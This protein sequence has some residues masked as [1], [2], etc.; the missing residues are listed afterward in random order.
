MIRVWKPALLQLLV[1]SVLTG[2]VYP[3]LVTALARALFPRQAEGGMLTEAGRKVGAHLIGQPFDQPRYF[4]GRL[5]A[6]VPVPYRG[7]A[8]AGSN[9]GPTNPAL[10]A[11]AAARIAALRAAD[12]G[13]PREVPVDLVTASGSGLDPEISPAAAAYQVARVARARGMAGADV[14][15]LVQRHTRGR[16]LGF[17]GEPGV[18][19]LE[20]NRELDRA[21]PPARPH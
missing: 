7:D 9:L 13:A 2:I 1:L 11:A 16:G 8:S 10:V 3:V 18:N 12:P 4:W 20:L 14:R 15:A 5:S 6:T 19:V 21:A 17:L